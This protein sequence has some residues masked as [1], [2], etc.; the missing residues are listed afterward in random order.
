MK[1]LLLVTGL[2][3][4]AVLIACGNAGAT[5]PTTTSGDGS[6]KIVKINGKSVEVDAYTAENFTPT[7]IGEA[8]AREKFTSQLPKIASAAAFGKK[9]AEVIWRA[10]VPHIFTTD[11]GT[12]CVTYYDKGVQITKDGKSWFYGNINYEGLSTLYHVAATESVLHRGVWEPV[13]VET[14]SGN[15]PDFRY[16]FLHKGKC[17]EDHWVL[18]LAFDREEFGINSISDL[19]V[20]VKEF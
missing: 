5:S 12:V 8:I 13:Y 18:L 9:R 15:N 19:Q 1:K 2:V 7:K 4:A 6:T 20:S 11:L 14:A 3:M 10:I 17:K 16:H